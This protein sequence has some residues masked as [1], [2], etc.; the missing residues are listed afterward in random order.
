VRILTE[1][2]NSLVR[3]YEALLATEEVALSSPKGN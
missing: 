2:E 1:P 3:Q